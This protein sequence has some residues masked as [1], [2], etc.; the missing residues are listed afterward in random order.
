MERLK[1]IHL[2]L[3]HFGV[4]EVAL[5]SEG[6]CILPVCPAVV[7]GELVIRDVCLP[8][9]SA[10]CIIFPAGGLRNILR[11]KVPGGRAASG[12]N[13]L[14]ERVWNKRVASHRLV[15]TGD[16]IRQVVYG[17][18]SDLVTRA[19]KSLHLKH[20]LFH[21]LRILQEKVPYRRGE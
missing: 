6:I 18:E 5:R 20:S 21:R 16:N 7:L 14:V 8:Y 11:D 13:E 9:L 15:E 10:P 1:G 19:K 17:H 12:R 3:G 2:I 4:S